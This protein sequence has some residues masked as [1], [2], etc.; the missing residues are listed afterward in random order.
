MIYKIKLKNRYFKNTKYFFCRQGVPS[1][2]S[3]EQA[4][5]LIINDPRYGAL[6][7]LNE[8]KQAFNAYKT[9]R[10]KEEK[11]WCTPVFG[12][13]VLGTARRH[14]LVSLRQAAPPSARLPP[15]SFFYFFFRITIII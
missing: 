9:L 6:K 3:W 15:S 10:A 13:S 8:K 5:K 2:S 11:V 7:H 14:A 12:L 4:M 1:T